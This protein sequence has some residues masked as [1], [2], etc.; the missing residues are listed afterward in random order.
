MK[1]NEC[2]KN[3]NISDFVILYALY[4]IENYNFYLLFNLN[5]LIF[6][7]SIIVLLSDTKLPFFKD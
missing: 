6:L 5:L 2:L 3:P 7:Q 4:N 1:L